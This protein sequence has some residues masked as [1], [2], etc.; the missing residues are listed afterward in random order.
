MEDFSN[1]C[2][3]YYMY[4]QHI[5]KVNKGISRR[6]KKKVFMKNHFVMKLKY[7]TLS[8][9][10]SMNFRYMLVNYTQISINNPSRIYRS[11]HS[12]DNFPQVHT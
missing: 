6:R 7:K 11:L 4:H 12:F 5:S 3:G 2:K 1:I 8:N 9:N 10:S